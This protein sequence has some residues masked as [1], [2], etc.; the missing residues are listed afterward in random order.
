[1]ADQ[2]GLFPEQ[3]PGS[4]GKATFDGGDASGHRARLRKRLMTGGDDALADHEVIEYLLMV[5]RPRIDTKP[6]ARS[7]IQ[8]FGSL[9]G[10]LNADPQALALHPN[11]GETSAAALR[12]VALAARRLARTVVREQPVLSNWQALL[13]Y[14]HIDMAHLNVERVR[15]LYLNTQNMLILDHLVGDGTL[16]ESPIYTREVVKKGLDVGAAAMILVHNHPSG[17]PKPS[18][19]DI[20]VTHKI[21]EAARMMGM[22]VHDHIVI[23]REGYTSLKAQ[24][25]I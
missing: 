8:R 3:I 16:D 1:M 11:M 14:L 9:A 15:V 22:T 6:I 13:D 23:G 19:A 21:T 12:I 4:G 17:S 2:T 25:L 24:G 20:Q 7:L 18:R 10:V 5:A